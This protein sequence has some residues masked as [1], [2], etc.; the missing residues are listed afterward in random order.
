MPAGADGHRVVVVGC[1]FGGL[2][3]IRALRDARVSITV[4]DRRNHHLFQPLLYQMATGILSAGDIAPPIR[5]ILRRRRNV[6][7]LLGDVVDI[8]VNTRHVV[9]ETLGRRTTVPYDSLI[10]ATGSQQSYF[11]NDRF[12]R[13]APG[14]KSLDDALELRGRIFGALELASLEPDPDKRRAWLTFVTVGAGATGV[15]MAGQIAELTSRSLDQN[16][17]T[18]SPA[19]VRVIVLDA[20]PRALAA[21]PESL[22]R[23]AVAD[24]EKMGV[25]VHLGVKVTDVDAY[26]LTTDSLDPTLRR[27][28]ARTKIWAAG[29]EASPLGRLLAERT[30]VGLDRVGRVK[31]EPDLTL[32]G[33]P[34]IFVIGDLATLNDLPG[35]AEVAMQGGW[36][37]ARTIR[38]RLEGHA[39]TRRFRYHDL[40]S[41]ATVSRFRAIATVGPLRVSG[42]PAWLIWMFVHLA[43]LTGFKNRFAV[44]ASWFI[45]FLGRARPQRAIT[46]QQVFGRQAL[47]DRS[48]TPD[49]PSAPS[50]NT[51]GSPVALTP[52]AH[53]DVRGS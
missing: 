15:E 26:G 12:A 21:F 23:K 5:H 45:A 30:G 6:R 22:A 11:G 39:A 38:A 31:V 10:V 52:G 49:V 28:E 48:R 44:L 35:V 53:P 20:A 17:G 27:I 37:V 47:A 2:Y 51:T 16:F 4:V 13:E 50:G 29:V 41:M 43:F 25:E 34:E 14:L 9:L 42:T 7:V 1:G 32:P 40:G 18:Y 19:Q 36:H 33:H 24:L 8:D 3:T 46:P